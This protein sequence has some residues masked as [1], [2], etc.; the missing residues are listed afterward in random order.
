MEPPAGFRST[1]VVVEFCE[2]GP[3]LKR[4][5][6]ADVVFPV[7]GRGP[8]RRRRRP[9]PRRAAGSWPEVAGMVVG[10]WP[11]ALRAGAVAAALGASAAFPLSGAGTAVTGLLCVLAVRG[12]RG[13]AGPLL[14]GRV[15]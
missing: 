2:A 9:A 8:R 12:L 5:Q 15:P 13:E 3:A 7:P 6:I 14:P 4:I 11:E 10:G 1:T